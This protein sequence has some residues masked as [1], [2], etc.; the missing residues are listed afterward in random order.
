MGVSQL[1]IIRNQAEAAARNAA[2]GA[3]SHLRRDTSLVNEASRLAGKAVRKGEDAWKNRKPGGVWQQQ[4]PPSSAAQ[5]GGTQTAEDGYVR[6]SPVQPVR[7]AENYRRTLV[8]RGVRIV[9]LIF[10][11]LLV[12][13]LLKKAG[14]LSW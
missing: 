5:Y 6:R 7:E 4:P 1:D 8:W 11:A 10:A 13:E 2:A 14:L 12:L 9:L 3:Q